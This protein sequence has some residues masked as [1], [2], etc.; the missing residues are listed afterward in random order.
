V[1]I[2]VLPSLRRKVSRQE[3]LPTLA[4]VRAAMRCGRRHRYRDRTISRSWQSGGHLDGVRGSRVIRHFSAE[5]FEQAGAACEVV[6]RLLLAARASR[7][8]LG[9][10]SCKSVRQEIDALTDEPQS[11]APRTRRTR[12]KKDRG[13][14]A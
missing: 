12:S 2:L 11:S 7:A 6:A 14:A 1:V 4:D 13:D 9:S 10:P 5:R 8:E 3:A